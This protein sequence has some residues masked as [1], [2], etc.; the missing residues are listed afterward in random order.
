MR[1]FKKRQYLSRVTSITGGAKYLISPLSV[2]AGAAVVGA[3]ATD[4]FYFVALSLKGEGVGF[5]FFS[6]F[7]FVFTPL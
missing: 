6:L 4:I 5:Y 1:I 2:E 7:M 3:V